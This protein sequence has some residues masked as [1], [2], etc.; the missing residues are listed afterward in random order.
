M[1]LNVSGIIRERNYN[2]NLKV[3]IENNQELDKE[4]SNENIENISIEKR[5]NLDDTNNKNSLDIILEEKR[6]EE[7]KPDEIKNQK[8]ISNNNILS[9]K[10]NLNKS[11]RNSDFPL[12]MKRKTM[13]LL[14]VQYSNIDNS[15][16]YK[17]TE[18]NTFRFSKPINRNSVQ[19]QTNKTPNYSNIINS[20]FYTD[21]VIK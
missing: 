3:I 8:K 16:S 5:N 6:L 14:N 2:K 4:N 20:I 7:N 1:S 17:N 15:S 13:K 9:E 19:T 18:K 12:L 21:N 10:F 11:E